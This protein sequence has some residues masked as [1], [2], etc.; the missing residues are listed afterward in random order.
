MTF[1]EPI[2]LIVSFRIN[3][4]DLFVEVAEECSKYVSSNEP[5]TLAYAWYVAADNVNG[6]LFETYKSSD[7]FRKHL[8][9]P[10][11]REIGPKF[12]QSITWVSIESFGHLPE[13]FHS[14][15]GAVPQTN[16]PVPEI[17]A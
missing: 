2:Q 10:V 4:Y 8:L 17:G 13:E 3:D 11:F 15:L 14:I 16:W 6:R 12:Q 5:E 9:G 7:A 1:I